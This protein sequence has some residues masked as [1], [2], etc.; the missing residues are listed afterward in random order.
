LAGARG[1]GAAKPD[2]P[3]EDLPGRRDIP[4]ISGGFDGAAGVD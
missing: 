3:A 2:Q 4:L 1:G